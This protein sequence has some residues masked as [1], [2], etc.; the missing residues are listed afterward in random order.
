ME[1]MDMHHSSSVARASWQRWLEAPVE[2]R[3][4]SVWA[5][6]LSSPGQDEPAQDSGPAS[7]WFSPH[8]SSAEQW[9]FLYRQC[10]QVA[11]EALLAFGQ[12]GRVLWANHACAALVGRA[13]EDLP[14]ARIDS[15]FG[16]GCPLAHT[17]GEADAAAEQG[18]T[19]EWEW[20]STHGVVPLAITCRRL[21][22]GR[23]KGPVYVAGLRD[24]SGIRAL[25]EK[26]REGQKLEA[27][28][29]LAAGL[30]H[31]L[32]SFLAGILG[33]VRFLLA[34]MEE[35]HAHYAELKSIAETAT[36]AIDLTNRL[37]ALTRSTPG[38]RLV[39]SINQLVEKTAAILQRSVAQ[40]VRIR[41]HLCEQMPS[42]LCNPSQIEQVLMN[43]GING[44]DAMPEGGEL[45]FRTGVAELDRDA[46][47]AKE[48][49]SPGRYVYFSVQDTGVGIPPYLQRK[50]FEPL[51][52]TKQPGKGTGMGLAVAEGIVR[53]HR[54]M[55]TVD[56]RVGVGSRFTV[57]LPVAVEDQPEP[58]HVE[59]VHA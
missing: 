46:L 59:A 32:K 5:G 21:E 55:I 43:L 16:W 1:H 42:V 33:C 34:G 38:Q 15:L 24:L 12:D 45:V 8:G 19:T 25:E 47:G 39:C 22:Q 26:L 4:P 36:T 54:G 37:L 10:A 41:L 35:R 30:A 11:A 40:N 48:Q 18:W 20:V 52:T 2:V 27:V 58:L 23:G 13:E 14:G 57:Y 50:I 9:A 6:D 7:G 51:F 49:V 44:A 31:D 53:E 56:S 3:A 17:P 28:G 29:S